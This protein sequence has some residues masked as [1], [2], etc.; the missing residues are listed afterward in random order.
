[1]THSTQRWN[2]DINVPRSTTPERALLNNHKAQP[3]EEKSRSRSNSNSDPIKG[4]MT[5]DRPPRPRIGLFELPLSGNQTAAPGL[6]TPPQI[7]VMAEAM[8]TERKLSNSSATN[9][10]ASTTMKEGNRSSSSPTT[11]TIPQPLVFRSREG[12]AVSSTIN[13]QPAAVPSSPSRRPSTSSSANVPFVIAMGSPHNPALVSSTASVQPTSCSITRNTPAK[14]TNP[15]LRTGLGGTMASTTPV[16]SPVSPTDA[17]KGSYFNSPMA[18][19]KPHAS[20]ASVKSLSTTTPIRNV[21]VSS[22]NKIEN[23]NPDSTVSNNNSFAAPTASSRS[24]ATTPSHSRNVSGSSLRTAI[25][26]NLPG[27]LDFMKGKG[28][29]RKDSISHPTPLA[30]PFDIDRSTSNGEGRGNGVGDN[31]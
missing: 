9:V 4:R 14:I 28:K 18:A 26:S 11:S 16:T 27:R 6:R 10:F 24:K 21:S 3:P 30:S 13:L 20:A 7:D 19:S 5:P 31:I 8:K 1:M 15:T 2:N 17:S 25:A 23:Q 12:S 22:K 29:A